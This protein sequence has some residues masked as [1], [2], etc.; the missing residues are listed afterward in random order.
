MDRKLIAWARAVKERDRG[1]RLGVSGCGGGVGGGLKACAAGGA[2]RRSAGPPR[3]WFFTDSYRGPDPIPV[4]AR[5]PVGLAGVVV[6][7]DMSPDRAIIAARLAR[8]CRSRR[9]AIVVAAD[10]RMAD[11]LGAGL[12]LRGGYRCRASLRKGRVVTSS[13]H[14]VPDLRRAAAAGAG[15]VFLSPAFATASHPGSPCLGPIRWGLFV[16]R[17]RMR[18]QVRVFALGGVT[19]G[20]VRRLPAFCGGVAAI[21]ALA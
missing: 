19:G 8:I 18:G 11:R 15:V 5:L 20:N 13:A 2:R 10:W 14:S 1:G 6:R 4:V 16:R 3:L 9:L 7:H 17:A 12:H 21:G